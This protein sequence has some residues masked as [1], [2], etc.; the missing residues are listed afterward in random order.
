MRVDMI[1]VKNLTEGFGHFTAVDN[2]CFKVGKGKR[3]VEHSTD[4]GLSAQS[5]EEGETY[6]RQEANLCSPR[7]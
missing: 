1:E 6:D 7:F 4:E 3:R 2:A 5:K